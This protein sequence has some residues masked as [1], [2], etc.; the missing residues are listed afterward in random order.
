MIELEDRRRRLVSKVHEAGVMVGFRL[1]LISAEVAIPELQMM[2]E[3][4]G[5]RPSLEV[6]LQAFGITPEQFSE[7]LICR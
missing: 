7:A 1:T 4:A 6:V 5:V 3:R 2:L